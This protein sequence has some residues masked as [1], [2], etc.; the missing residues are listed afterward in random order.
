MCI[1][2]STLTACSLFYVSI[3]SCVNYLESPDDAICLRTAHDIYLKHEKYA[4]ALLIAIRMSDKTL[5]QNLF[6]NCQDP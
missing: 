1:R 2:R 3:Y 5:I 4:E 6:D